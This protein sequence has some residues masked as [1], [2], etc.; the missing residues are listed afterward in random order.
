MRTL[1]ILASWCHVI[2]FIM[3]EVRHTARPSW[4]VS[5]T[6][7]LL[8]GGP[9]P[10]LGQPPPPGVHACGVGD[11]F[12]WH[13]A[14]MACPVSFARDGGGLTT[15]PGDPLTPVL[16]NIRARAVEAEGK[17]CT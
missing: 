9:R 7:G 5:D 12:T 2:L 10:T 16:S 17:P 1:Q 14:H 11:R 15:D 8:G 4:M 3:P 6:I 13:G